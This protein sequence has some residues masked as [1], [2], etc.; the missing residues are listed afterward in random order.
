MLQ[1][2]DDFILIDDYC[3]PPRANVVKDFLLEKGIIRMEWP[4]C[5][6]DLNP[7]VHV[8]DIIGRQVAGR[9]S[10]PQTL[11]GLERTLL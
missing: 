10:P 5:S 7:I 8:W 6:P 4:A 1:D 2:G 9:L 3:R 11:Q